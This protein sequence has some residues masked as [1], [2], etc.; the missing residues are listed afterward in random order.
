M[1]KKRGSYDVC[2]CTC[3]SFLITATAA[4]FLSLSLSLSLSPLPLSSLSLFMY[5]LSMAY[6]C[7]VH[8]TTK[9]DVSEIFCDK[10]K[11]CFVY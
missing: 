3:I 4:V 9:Q 11:V 8:L 10:F 5:G 6:S 2:H 1:C 7:T